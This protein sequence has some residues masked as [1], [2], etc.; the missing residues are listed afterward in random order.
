MIGKSENPIEWA[1]L[2]YQLEDAAEHLT[3][4]IREM[5]ERED[6][7]EPEFRIDLGHIFAHLNRAWHLRN[8]TGE[9]A[10]S[11]SDEASEFPTDLRP[12]G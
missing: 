11:L 12:I 3:K 8:L 7:D 2:V 6:Y 10:Q 9:E 5:S 1:L 4:L